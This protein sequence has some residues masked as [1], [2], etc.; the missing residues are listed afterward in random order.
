[1][2]HR[3]CITVFVFLAVTA[4]QAFASNNFAP[5]MPRLDLGNFLIFSGRIADREQM[6]AN[7]F[8]VPGFVPYHGERL[9]NTA[10][11]D[12]YHVFKT[13]FTI[14]DHFADRNLT[15]YI[16]RFAMPVTIRINDII[17]YKKGLRLDIDGAYSTGQTMAVHVPLSLGLID[18][19]RENFL[20][21]EVFPQYESRPLPALSIAEFRYNASRVFFKNLLN[22]H[23]VLAAQFVAMLIALY[24]FFAFVSKGAKDTRYIF[25]AL[26]SMSF[27]LAYSN[28]GFSFDSNHY[29]LLV[30]ITRSFQLL[31]IGFYSL[32]LIETTGLF[33]RQKK[34]VVAGITIFSIACAA[35]IAF[36]PDKEAV[37]A[38]FA[39]TN[40][41]YFVPVLLFCIGIPVAAIV[42]RKN[43]KIIP[44]LIS[45]LIVAAA[46]LRDMMA[47]NAGTEPLFWYAP[48][49]FLILVIAIYGILV[50]DESVLH[51]Q[52]IKISREID[53]KNRSLNLLLDNIIKVIKN[54]SDSNQKLDTSIANTIAIMTEYT[55][56]N[57]RIDET[58]LSQFQI[59][60]EM[61]T[62]VSERVRDF[63]DNIPKAIGDQVSIVEQT[64]GIIEDMN[65]DIN[66][67]ADDSVT[68]NDYAKQLASLA[69]ESKD[70]ILESRKNMELISENS[71]F[72]STM[73]QSIDH[74]SEQTNMLS[75]NASIEAAR[76]GNAGK[77]FSVVA[78][79]IRQLAEKSKNTLTESFTN[80]KGMMDTVKNGIELSNKVT[81]RLLTIIENSGKSSEMID[82]ITE[83][84][85][86]QRRES[87]TIR[88]GMTV[89]LTGTNQ[90]QG[91]AETEQQANEGVVESLSKMHQFFKQVSD[92]VNAQV[93]NEKSIAESI[94]IIEDVM[95]EN[96]RNIQML[97]TATNAIQRD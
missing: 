81:Q 16:D 39:L 80:I 27:A 21:V 54:S 86:K 60:N 12:N 19:N 45:T 38:A 64:N 18:F 82:G 8:N 28:V 32:F 44:L 83:S 94:K 84:M 13:Y 46:S 10:S 36:Q 55:H 96:K 59:I 91:M 15:L 20:V 25:F 51:K 40:F 87:E 37:S 48:Y 52:S 30:K 70:L 3:K 34:P 23:L 90:I 56:G 95:N 62:K 50:Y 75:F 14:S 53:E 43:L 65:N 17:V 31:S 58:I 67:M 73:L 74:I 78:V 89:L 79:E 47:L 7:N 76:A 69:I 68:T 66:L 93:K 97:T 6:L 49:A 57:K 5:G 92:M 11:G 33:A 41:V 29:T 88:S 85:K 35:F 42:S 26:F 24:H 2:T 77:G 22:I 1:M 61:I 9:R 63:A 4:S 72:L 71:A